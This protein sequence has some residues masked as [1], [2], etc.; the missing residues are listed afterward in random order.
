MSTLTRTSAGAPRLRAE[1]LLPLPSRPADLPDDPLGFPGYAAKLGDARDRH[2]HVDESVAVGLATLGGERVVAAIGVFDFLG[3]SMGRVHGERIARAL[4]TAAELQVPFVAVTASGGARMQEGML[5]LVQMAR[6]AEGIRRLR[7]AG[8]PVLA[9]FTSPT[10]GGVHASYGALADVIVADEG[11]TVGFAGPRVV[12]AAGDPVGLDSHT[13]E[14][15]LKAGLVDDVAEPEDAD[16]H[17]AAWVRLVHPARR[18]GALPHA[19][20]VDEPV[21]EHD[22]WAAIRAARRP[23]R[24][25]ARDLLRDV[26]DEHRELRGDRAGED[27]PAVVAA[28]ARLGERRLVVVGMDRRGRSPQPGR[29]PGQP[30]AAG[31][32]KLRRAVELAARWELGLVSFIDT[33]GAD[34]SPDSDRGGLAVTIAETFVST[35]GVGAPTVAVVT[36]EGGSGGALALG[37]TDRLLMQD[38]A[39]F[40]VIAPEGAASILHRDPTRAEEVAPLLRP[41][42]SELRRL[43][44]A[45]R[46]L[47]GPTTFDPR[48]AATA[49][50]A[51]LAA[52]IAELDADADRLARRRAR[53]GPIG[54]PGTVDR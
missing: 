48:T 46:V 16:A 39:V 24:P 30:T 22:A 26:F 44:I 54:G 15:A 41:T 21:V 29:R 38:D 33:P 18:D 52:T 5:S 9:R 47:P 17:L 25:S 53:Y 14:A 42:A 12:E 2:T 13:A 32:R 1:D 10:T 37:C 45:D 49:L 36:G 3:G 19:S 4:A 6:A 20:H 27:D 50:R 35:L 28:I 34:L 43:G 8:I 23:D 51:E 7:E 31:F 11:A 40:E